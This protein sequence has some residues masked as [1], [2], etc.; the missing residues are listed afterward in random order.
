MGNKEVEELV[1]SLEE[2]EELYTRHM[3]T[4]A[5]YLNIKEK[6]EGDKDE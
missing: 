2:L 4:Y 3:V 1:N 5:Q 6:L